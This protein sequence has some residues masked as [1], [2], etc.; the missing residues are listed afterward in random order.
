[1]TKKQLLILIGISLADFIG[2]VDFTIVNTAL[3]VLQNSFHATLDQ[4]QWVMNAFIL[5]LTS[6]MII[7]GRLADIYGRR[8]MLYIGMIIFGIAS[9]GAGLATNIYELIAFRFLQGVGGAISF[10]MPLSLVASIFSA[11]QTGKASGIL[12]G[13]SSFGL[14]VGPVLGGIIVAGLSWRWIFLVNIPVIIAGFLLLI[15]NLQEIKPENVDKKIDWLGFALLII[16]IPSFIFATSQG[17]IFGWNSI[18]IISLYSIAFI[19]FIL[20]YFVE[21]QVSS[22]ILQFSLF[23]DTNFLIGVIANF[24]LAFFYA[25]IFFLMPIYLHNFQG[26]NAYEIGLTLFP[27]TL[28]TAILS[29]IAGRLSD[30]YGANK[31]LLMGFSLL[32]LSALMIARFSPTTSI[33]FVISALMVFG[34]GWG[35]IITPA[36]AGAMLSVAQSASGTAMGTIGTIHNAG[37]SV[38]LAVSVLIYSTLGYAST[39]YS[40]LVLSIITFIVVLL[41]MKQRIAGSPHRA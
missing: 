21:R 35:C 9:L 17:E 14:A 1:M 39:I 28:M 15:P 24:S 5:A 41:G 38:G 26:K 30:K 8:L 4:L 7:I 27:T 11:E 37:G 12:I 23:S 31:I 13:V 36:I 29:P 33:I 16:T 22:P 10:T 32:A 6:L 20:F 25:T 34:I 3:P 2:C 40:L 18:L 19:S